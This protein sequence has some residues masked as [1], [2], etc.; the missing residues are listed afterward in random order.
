MVLSA[1][2]FFSKMFFA[3]LTVIFTVGYFTLE[4]HAKVVTRGKSNLGIIRG[5]VRDQAGNPI[6][7]AYVIISHLGTKKI[8]KQ[9]RSAANGSFIAKI[10]PG[11]Y[12]ILTV[13]EGFNPIEISQVE[14]N[15]ASEIVYKFN[16]ERA[17]SGNTLPEKKPDRNSSKWRIRNAQIRSSIYQN[18]ES[19]TPLGTGE[20]NEKSIAVNEAESVEDI[21]ISEKEKLRRHG[22]TVIETFVGNTN[23]ENF[24]GTN[25]ATLLP[26]NENSELVLAG[27]M[28]N[29]PNSPRRLEARLNLRPA[30]NHQIRISSAIAKFENFQINDAPKSLGQFSLQALDEWRIKN[31]VILVLGVDY[32][33]FLGAGNDFSLSPRFGMQYSLNSKTRFRTSYTTKTEEKTWERAIELEDSTVL[34]REPVAGQ[35]IVVEND[36]PVMNKSSR[37]EFG[38]ERVL[39]NNS[40]IEANVFFDFTNGRGVGLLN[41]PIDF[42]SNEPN[43]FVANQQGKSQG[44]RIVYSRRINGTLSTMAGYSFGNGQKLSENGFSNPANLFENDFFQTFFGQFNAD[45]RNGT[46]VKT[47]FRLSSQAT[48]FAIDP[49]QGRLMIYDPGLSVIVTQNLPTLGLPIRAEAVID[50]RNLFDFQS[51]VSGEEGKLKLVS[52]R[53]ALRGGIMLRF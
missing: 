11:T 29:N 52:Q 17:G 15:R 35:E 36:K 22:Q 1:S 24:I 49:F 48:V 9:V 4:T 28:T 43:E 39:D 27:Q 46:Q 33:R 47:V 32:S 38:V 20:P 3:A 7:D 2:N 10:L 31:G 42:L 26:L 30:D 34:F 8:F 25:I 16:L 5:S 6:S 18:R 14:V 12:K 50:A 51:V 45:L 40:S 41:V 37:F 44:I 21:L 23:G 53:R 19:E 13:A